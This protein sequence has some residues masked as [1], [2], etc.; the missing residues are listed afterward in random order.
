[1]V[2][3][4]MDDDGV[5]KSKEWMG[6]VLPNDDGGASITS[7]C[8]LSST[9]VLSCAQHTHTHARDSITIWLWS[10]NIPF[11]FLS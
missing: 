9:S 7:P 6:G 11:S 10:E 8:V 5:E 3:V 4:C 1:M 2:W